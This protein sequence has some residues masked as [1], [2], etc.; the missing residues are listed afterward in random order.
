MKEYKEYIEGYKELDEQ[1][2]EW[3]LLFKDIRDYILPR[4]GKFIDD[5]DSAAGGE[6]QHHQ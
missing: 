2:S 5:V 4:R 6:N 3:K 1:F